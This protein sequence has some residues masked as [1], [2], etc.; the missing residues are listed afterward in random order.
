MR[1][2]LLLIFCGCVTLT[3]AA[4]APTATAQKI[5]YADT[6][7]IF[8]QLPEFK[9]ISDELNTYGTKLKNQIDSKQKEFQTKV[10]AYQQGEATMI[11][12]VKKS[13]QMELAQM[14]ENIA[15]F[16]QDA[17]TSYQSK[18]ATLTEP[19]ITKVGK[20]IEDVAKENGYDFIFSPS[21]PSQGL[22]SDILLYSSDKYDISNLVLKKLGVTP[23]PVTPPAAGK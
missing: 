14:E 9:Q 16:Q 20:A 7:Y 22:A 4:Q 15:K 6:E 17:Q 5:G 13:T 2:L 18:S 10:A 19:I 23:K 1:T 8:E 11:D 21:I 3:A 12:A